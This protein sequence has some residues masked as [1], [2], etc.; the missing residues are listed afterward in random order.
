[1][2][3]M[4]NLLI[5]GGTVITM[6]P[7]R[8]VLEADILVRGDRIAALGP[9]LSAYQAEAEVIDA[10]GQVVMPGLIQSHI[11]LTQTLFRGLADDL[12]LLDW[13]KQRIWPL[14]AAHS[15]ASNAIS[16]RLGAAELIA[17]GTTSVIDMG[18]V[19]HTEAIFETMR[20]VGLRGLFG[21]CLM[22]YGPEVPAGLMQGADTALAES[23]ELLQRW[24]ES[25][26]GRLRYAFA[27]RFAVSCTTK[28]ME[29]VRDRARHHGVSVHT[30]SSEN[31]G[32]IALVEQE[33]GK[34]NVHF[35][36]DLGMTGPDLILAHCV[37]LDESE[38]RVLA[39]TGT[40]AVHC[41][42]SNMKLAS[43]IAKVP[44]LLDMGVNMALGC[45]GPPCNNNL[46]AFL[47]MRHAALL[48]KVRTLSPTALP[49]MQVLEMATLHGARVLRQETD[50]GSLE[51]GKKADITVV[52]L[53]R[54]HSSPTVQ[55]D[56]V[57]A[58]VYSAT[59]HNVTHTVVDG[60]VLYRQ[61]RHTTLHVDDTLREAE[62]LCGELLQR[63]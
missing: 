20:D 36:H 6:N 26:G 38:M 31:R 63:Y 34:R 2:Q 11:H 16:A 58:V 18:T 17:G 1:M 48:Q 10:T 50:L 57:A 14:E 47:E 7:A 19:H 23:E 61:G 43:G 30:H 32:E 45:D 51:V 8:Q 60:R 39:D 21:K 56:P 4:Q 24:H 25:A 9:N 3:H 5:K 62:K 13:L 37:W 59:A 15:F 49:A 54:P 46:D 55:R 27:P 28:L 12:E 40:H 33:R 52:D 44:E 41:P 29:K 22:D 42:S 35:F 53:R